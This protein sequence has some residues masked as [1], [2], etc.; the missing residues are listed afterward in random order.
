MRVN[1]AAKENTY[2]VAA[3]N[4]DTLLGTSLIASDPNTRERALMFH[5]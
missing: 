2:L 1:L 4:L 3:K 5:P